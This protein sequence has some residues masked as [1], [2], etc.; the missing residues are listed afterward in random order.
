MKPKFREDKAAQA[1]ALF[2]KHRGASLSCQKMSHLKLMKLLYL[3]EREALIRW[4]R[5]IIFDSYVSMD[6]GPVLSQTLNLL[7]GESETSGIWGETISSPTDNEVSLIRDPGTNSLSEAEELLIKEIFHEYGRMSRWEIC[8]KTHE[9][10]EWE[11]P[12]GSSI[13]IEYRDI[14][15]GAGKTDIE[16]A[17]IIS[18]IENIALID[19]YLG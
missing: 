13:P 4:R 19:N 3:A 8:D 11:N 17:S 5:P 12:E 7:H 6:K 1:A 16:I 15:K 18:E 10:P 9:L 14:L 2:L